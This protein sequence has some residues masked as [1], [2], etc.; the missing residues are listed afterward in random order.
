[1]SN[2]TAGKADIR[3]VPHTVVWVLIAISLCHLLNDMMQSL[4][5]A[6]YPNLKVALGWL[7]DATSIGFVYKVC[8]FLL[9]LGIFAALLPD[10]HFGRRAPA[11]S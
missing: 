1:M 2:V 9:A 3:S 4:L 11:D 6:M 7:A 10:L 8:S 5:P